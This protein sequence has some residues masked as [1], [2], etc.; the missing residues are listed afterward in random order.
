MLEMRPFH[1]QVNV[2][3][4]VTDPSSA[5]DHHTQFHHELMINLWP[6]SPVQ[7]QQIGGT[8]FQISSKL[9]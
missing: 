3:H 7:N 6:S 8:A 5:S 1:L 4:R 9:R 2:S